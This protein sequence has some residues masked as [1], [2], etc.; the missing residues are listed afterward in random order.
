MGGW[1]LEEGKAEQMMSQTMS[2]SQLSTGKMVQAKK[3]GDFT[4]ELKKDMQKVRDT[5]KKSEKYAA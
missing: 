1:Q 5:A 3:R 2:M 4:A